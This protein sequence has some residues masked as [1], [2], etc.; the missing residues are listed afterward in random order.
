MLVWYEKAKIY[1]N[2]SLIKRTE[3]QLIKP[4]NKQQL[5]DFRVFS[6]SS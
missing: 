1:S 3:K 2:D 4:L 5:C 6:G